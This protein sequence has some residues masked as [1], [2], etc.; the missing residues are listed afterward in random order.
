VLELHDLHRRTGA[1][2]DAGGLLAQSVW[3]MRAFAI[4]DQTTHKAPSGG[5]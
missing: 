3:L 5:N 4:I 1:L 2:P